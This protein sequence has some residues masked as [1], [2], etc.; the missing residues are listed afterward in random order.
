[1]ESPEECRKC[2]SELDAPDWAPDCGNC[3]PYTA[4]IAVKGTINNRTVAG[5]DTITVHVTDPTNAPT[6]ARTQFRQNPPYNT[7]ISVN[8]DR[9]PDGEYLDNW[10]YPSVF[11]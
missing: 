7:D 10:G 4:I 3:E 1:M 8:K 6:K 2:G 5:I 11:S 9:F